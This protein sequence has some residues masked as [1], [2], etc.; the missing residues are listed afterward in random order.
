M[1][2]EELYRYAMAH[3][4]PESELLSSLERETNVKIYHPRMLSGLIQGKLLKFIS[5][6][7]QPK[8]ILEIGTYTGYSAL[9]MA[10]GLIDDGILFTI[11]INDELEDFIRS[12]IQR[13]SFTEKIKLYIGDARI[14]VP[15]IDETFDL[16]YIDGDKREYV[17]YY[18][19][20]INKVRTGGF[21]IVDNVFWNGK[22]IDKYADDDITKAIRT[23]NDLVH[24]DG[25]VENLMLPLR[26]GLTILRKR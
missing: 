16:V 8:R 15:N 7:L 2:F 26:D 1:M 23:F 12:Y 10:E 19:V 5:L 14:I 18:N 9:C 22:V 21:I 24:N 11:E 3:T 17:D 4:E 13:S 6:M 25:R 20:V